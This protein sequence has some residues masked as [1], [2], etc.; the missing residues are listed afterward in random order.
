MRAGK[1][2]GRQGQ[3]E[4]ERHSTV[5]APSTNLCHDK[6]MQNPTRTDAVLPALGASRQ[7]GI[8]ADVLGL[9]GAGQVVVGRARSLQTLKR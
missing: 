9:V 7:A 6:Q 3:S 2:A 1:G 4:G 5:K 8:L